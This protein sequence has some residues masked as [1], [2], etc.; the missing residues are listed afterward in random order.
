MAADLR[1][2]ESGPAKA[3]TESSFPNASDVPPLVYQPR[4]RQGNGAM[5][6]WMLRIL[7]ASAAE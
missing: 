6:G 3:E 1:K 2:A 5:P 7:Q 4:E